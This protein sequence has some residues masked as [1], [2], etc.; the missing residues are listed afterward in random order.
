MSLNKQKNE[1]TEEQIK[2][3]ND[4]FKKLRRYREILRE[5]MQGSVAITWIENEE[6]GEFLAY[7][8]GESIN[9]MKSVL[10]TI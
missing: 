9:E 5:N 10:S 7:T 4:I 3:A 1:M 2:L 6:S 8:L